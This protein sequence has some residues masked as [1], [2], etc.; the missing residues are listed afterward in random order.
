MRLSDSL[1]I[2]VSLLTLLQM[3]RVW[4]FRYHLPRHLVPM[5]TRLVA[6][7]LLL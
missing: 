5:I 3:M 2:R 4:G 7:V 1:R 6:P